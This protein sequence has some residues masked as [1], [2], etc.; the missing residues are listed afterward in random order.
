MFDT[1]RLIDSYQIRVKTVSPSRIMPVFTQEIKSP[2]HEIRPT[3]RQILNLPDFRF[4]QKRLFMKAH[5]LFSY[6]FCFMI[7]IFQKNLL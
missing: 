6:L 7:D 1:S 3:V 2:I 4:G 5:I